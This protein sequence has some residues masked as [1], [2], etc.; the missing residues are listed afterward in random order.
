MFD[1]IQH[2]GYLVHDLDAA[3]AWYADGFGGEKAGGSALAA[4]GIIPSGGRNAFVHFGKVEVELIEPEDKTG[5]PADTLVMHH[6]GYAVSDINASIVS[7]KAR[8]FKFFSDTP[9]TN[10][11]GQQV[12]YFDPASTNGV[13]MHLTQ[14]PSQPN[15]TGLD[16]GVKVDHIVHAGYLVN[17]LD[18]AIAWY[19]D[20]L[21]GTH[22]GGGPSRR[23]GRNA[24]VNFGEV[25]VELIEPPDPA[26][27]G[28]AH[29]LDHVGYVALDIVAAI[30]DCRARGF[31]FVADAPNTNTVGQQVLYFETDSTKS[32]RMHLT[33]LPA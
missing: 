4:G 7:L 26:A 31:R 27:L 30:A 28:A 24:F 19:V 25:Q 6:V 18:D 5:L 21:G 1:K 32:S 23:G 2:I 8:G 10:V 15:S 17:N 16:A 33:Q 13:L 20:K 9:N 22:L 14:L 12:L 3:V 11:L 29:S